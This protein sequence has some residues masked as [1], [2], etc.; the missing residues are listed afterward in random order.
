MELWSVRR[1]D[2]L[3]DS[4]PTLSP[5]VL[6]PLAWTLLLV[7]IAAAAFVALRRRA[8]GGPARTR[9]DAR[10]QP[11][12]AYRDELTSL[13]LSSVRAASPV[14]ARPVTADDGEAR[15][16][17]QAARPVSEAARPVSEAARP[18]S[19]AAE[20][21]P[22]P[23]TAAAASA[24]GP[25]ADTAVPLVLQALAT[26]AGRPA[27][28]VRH[29]GSR[30]EVVARTDDG[31]LTTIAGSALDL[32]GAS[33]KNA[34]A[35][36]GLSVLVGGRA[37]AV[38]A[39][40]HVVL[41]GLGADQDLEDGVLDRFGDLVAALAPPGPEGAASEAGPEAD[42]GAGLEDDPPALD[43]GAPVPRAVIIEREQ[44]AA[45]SQGRPLA[46]ALVTLADAE[47][48]LTRHTAAEAAQASAAL[49]DRLEDADHVRRVEP[50][51]DLL[52]GAFVERDP[53]GA[54]AWCRDLSASDPPLFIGAVAPAD[55]EPQAVRDAAAS[56]LR[57]AYDQQRTRIVEA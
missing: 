29:D 56:A 44:A 39:G 9:P 51:G 52:F 38:P 16:S 32:E 25:F 13:G 33:T 2:T 45:R 30:F 24:S 14:T 21:A 18:S 5:V 7:A 41:V 23:K 27:A 50:F 4:V 1:T 6:G 42:S 34:A 12:E 53:E 47:E 15:P 55:G 36:G 40:D 28:I 35:L 46:F 3:P 43:D 20:R 10:P 49:R 26:H 54:A 48:I 17:P 37:R 57:D 22:A 31:P 19:R 11:K 8:G